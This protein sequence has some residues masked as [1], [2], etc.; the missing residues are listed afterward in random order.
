MSP[1]YQDITLSMTAIL[2][3]S[4]LIES[5]FMARTLPSPPISDTGSSEDENPPIS[6]DSDKTSE[7]EISQTDGD[8]CKHIAKHPQHSF[9]DLPKE[10]R[11]RILQ[12]LTVTD[13]MKAAMV[14]SYDEKNIAAN[15]QAVSSFLYIFQVCHD[16]KNLAFDGSLWNNID[17]TPYY[18]NITT[19][20]LLALG[21]AAG[22]FLKIANFR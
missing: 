21:V 18:K 14:N 1:I 16:W 3:P 22:R 9:Q 7:K 4:T 19:E 17:V 20:Q 10:L 8:K 5:D 11:I 13:L 15:F 2:N 12:L 6:D